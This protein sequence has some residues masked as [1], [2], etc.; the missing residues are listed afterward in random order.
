MQQFY[1]VE[2][3]LLD[4]FTNDFLEKIPKQQQQIDLM[5]SKGII[6]SYSLALNR[7][8]LWLIAGAEDEFG[9]MKIIDKLSLSEFMIPSIVPLMFHNTNKPVRTFTLN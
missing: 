2:F 6:K 7:S 1:M 4:A 3:E 9:I 5:M 8:K